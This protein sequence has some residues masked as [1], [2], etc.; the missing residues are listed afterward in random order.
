MNQTLRRR[1]CFAQ[2]D[3][4]FDGVVPDSYNNYPPLIMLL[5]ILTAFLC[6]E[7]CHLIRFF[8]LLETNSFIQYDMSVQV[9]RYMVF[10][11]GEGYEDGQPNAF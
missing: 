7:P 11:S 9:G 10:H 1:F 5:A 8:L 2:A 6:F 3:K 4:S